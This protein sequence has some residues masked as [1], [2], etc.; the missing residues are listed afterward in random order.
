MNELK[1]MIEKA[2]EK[3]LTQLFDFCKY[4]FSVPTISSH[5]HNHHYRVWNYCKEILTAI[6]PHK[7]ISC[8][9]IEGCIIAS[10]FH[11]TG[12]SNTINEY[13]GTESKKICRNYFIK[14]KLSYP[15]NFEDILWTIENHDDKDY[16]IQNQKNNS[17]I[18][19]LSTAD[20]LDAFG[21]IGIVRYTEI[22]L[23]RGINITQLPTM[24]IN[25]INKRFLNFKF[26]YECYPD[27]YKK[28]QKRY[29][30]TKNFFEELNRENNTN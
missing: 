26:N 5:N 12:L 15:Q 8:E 11:D 19:I 29:L 13:H 16:R 22:Y 24:V 20:D 10:F 2:E 3:W 25:N 17:M 1:Q 9:L 18:T 30:I 7:K 4:V 21:K 23:L 14:N 6:Y 28:H 27:L